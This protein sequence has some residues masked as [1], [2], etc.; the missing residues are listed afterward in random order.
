[1]Q[2][3]RLLA[4]TPSDASKRLRVTPGALERIS[5]VAARSPVRGRFRIF[6]CT[7]AVMRRSRQDVRKC[8]TDPLPQ[9][10]GA[11]NGFEPRRS[12][13]IQPFD[14]RHLWS[15]GAAPKPFRHSFVTTRQVHAEKILFSGGMNAKA[16]VPPDQKPE[17]PKSRF[18][19]EITR[20]NHRVVITD[21]IDKERYRCS[22]EK[23]MK[24]LVKVRARQPAISDAF[25][26]RS[27]YQQ[28]LGSTC[29]GTRP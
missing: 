28:E 26:A 1:M 4:S 18:R 22:F 9:G 11:G 5:S 21:S 7:W 13:H 29:H 19:L 25:N 27:N 14:F 12:R 10:V 17:K 6:A 16:Q 24:C 8:G 15:L 20:H 2:T 3:K 23:A